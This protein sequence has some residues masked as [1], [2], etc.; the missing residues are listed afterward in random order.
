[1]TVFKRGS[2]YKYHFVVD[3]VHNQRSTRQGNLRVAREM[4]AAHRTRLA[5]DEAGK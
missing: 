2:V 3:G 1:M 5:K 4:E